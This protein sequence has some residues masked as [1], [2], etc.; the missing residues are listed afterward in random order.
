MS[1]EPNTETGALIDFPVDRAQI[2]RKTWM[3]RYPAGEVKFQRL[4]DI[5]KM[6]ALNLYCWTEPPLGDPFLEGTIENVVRRN[7]KGDIRVKVDPDTSFL[8]VIAEDETGEYHYGV[9]LTQEMFDAGDDAA[10]D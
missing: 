6:R 9:Q 2:R 3:R 10:T 4:L 5:I 1:A 8:V 7:V